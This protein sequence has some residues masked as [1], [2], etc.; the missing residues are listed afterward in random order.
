M[1][2]PLTDWYRG[3]R[4]L[5][6]GHTGFKGSWLVAW[7][8]EAGA[9]VTGFALAPDHDRPALFRDAALHEGIHSVIGDIRDAMLIGSTCQAA[10]PEIVFHLAAQSLVLQSYREPVETFATNVMGTT[11][12][13]EAVRKTPSVR[14]VVVV[15]SDKCYE[16]DGSGAPLHEDAPMGGHDP[17]S[18]SKGCTELVAAAWR[19]A[20]LAEQGVALAT[21]RAGN[22]FGGGD[23]AP[24]RLFP[25]LLGAAGRGEVS[26]VRHPSAV[27]PWQYVL[28]PLQGYL[29]LGRALTETGM[30]AAEGW[31]FGPAAED[32]LP[33]REI[34]AQLHQSWPAVTLAAPNAPQ[35]PSPHEAATLVLDANKAR[36]RLGW[37]PVFTLQ[38]ALAATTAFYRESLRRPDAIGTLMQDALSDY[39]THLHTQ[40][41]A[42]AEHRSST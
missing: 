21:A 6:T 2:D 16:N 20:F 40:T 36:Q 9:E 28:E 27:R 18:A 7:L 25:D 39:L 15:T 34:A 26:T 42:T 23:W 3:R 30:A 19:R 33:V 29:L 11:H 8:R 13:L 24:D 1:T 12:L 32:A 38:E 22:V 5:V 17:Y 37:R 41:S 4:V 14:S 10:A 31:N 35:P